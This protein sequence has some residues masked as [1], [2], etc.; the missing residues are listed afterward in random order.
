MIPMPDPLFVGLGIVLL[1]S[2]LA[3]VILDV[4]MI[5]FVLRRRELSMLAFW[6]GAGTLLGNGAYLYTFHG[7]VELFFLVYFFAPVP[8]GFL[9]MMVAVAKRDRSQSALR[10]NQMTV[11]TALAFVLM[12]V[13]FLHVR[14]VHRQTELIKAVQHNSTEDAVA[15]LRAGVAH[16]R[17]D[18]PLREDLLLRA[19]SAGNPRVVAALLEAGADPNGTEAKRPLHEA[20]GSADE[21]YR[22][23]TE[24][25]AMRTVQT[26]LERG[27]NPNASAKNKTTAVQIACKGGRWTVVRLLRSK[28][29]NQSCGVP[30]HFE[31]LMIAA[32]SGDVARV[33]ELAVGPLQTFQHD[34]EYH[35]PLRAAVE[36]NSMDTINALIEI[37]QSV[38]DGVIDGAIKTAIDGNNIVALKRFISLRPA[39]ACRWMGYAQ[40]EPHPDSIQ[41][42]KDAGCP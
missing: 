25:D 32:R 7:F 30:A 22:P 4:V 40:I 3:S 38:G 41:A 23:A 6:I 17:S 21:L 2:A 14:S 18:A 24:E 5:V 12:I 20:A 16:R 35:S 42:L 28:G 37:Y 29:A 33:K 27:A 39:L 31:D 10:T 13:I 26:L 1:I 9:T 15:L 34:S 19:A 36:S 8:F 11:V